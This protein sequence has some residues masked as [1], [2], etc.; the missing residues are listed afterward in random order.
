MDKGTITLSQSEWTVMEALWKH[1]KTLMELVRELGDSAHWAKSTVTT[2]VR[3]M[4]EKGII[5]H[6]MQ[7]RAKLFH[8]AVS[9]EAVVAEE[10]S[11][12]L[13]RAYHG[14]I[15]LMLSAMTKKQ[16]LSKDDI[17]ELRDILSQAEEGLK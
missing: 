1:P 9:R 13:N 4:E 3:R 17:Q 12:L 11:S 10:T 7:G 6:E 14:S 15:S 8:A 2:M 5:T 16:N